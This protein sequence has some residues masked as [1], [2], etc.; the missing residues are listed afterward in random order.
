MYLFKETFLCFVASLCIKMVLCFPLVVTVTTPSRHF[1]LS[2]HENKCMCKNVVAR[3]VC[4][5]H[6]HLVHV[7]VM[8]TS[9]MVSQ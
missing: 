1:G 5:E 4:V 8:Y 2:L 3:F 6:V 9:Q 7:K